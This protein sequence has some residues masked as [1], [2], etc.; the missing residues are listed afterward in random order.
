MKTKDQDSTRRGSDNAKY[1]Q[2]VVASRDYDKQRAAGVK[3]T[4]AK[5]KKPK[6][7]KESGK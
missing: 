6:K 1:E 3:E 7:Q 2:A 5:A 4:E